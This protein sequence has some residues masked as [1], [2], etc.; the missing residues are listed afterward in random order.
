MRFDVT[1]VTLGELRVKPDNPMSEPIVEDMPLPLSA[2][3]GQAA[4]EAMPRM[5]D[6]ALFDILLIGKNEVK[7]YLKLTQCGNV[8]K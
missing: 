6:F 1:V 7:L 4:N 3:F 5:G 2:S 8:A